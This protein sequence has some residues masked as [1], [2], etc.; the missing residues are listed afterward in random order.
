MKGFTE[1]LMY[2]LF[3]M[4]SISLMLFMAEICNGYIPII[5]F[6]LGAFFGAIS[7]IIKNQEKIISL[8]ETNPN[9]AEKERKEENRAE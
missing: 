8:L 9:E 4:A 7:T 6:L 1:C 2:I 3:T 5:T